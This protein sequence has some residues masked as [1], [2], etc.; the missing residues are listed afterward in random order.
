MEL[1]GNLQPMLFQKNSVSIPGP[2]QTPQSS[3]SPTQSSIS[4]QI[5]SCQHLHLHYISTII[6]FTNTIINI[7]AN[8][9]IVQSLFSSYG[10]SSTSPHVPS[11]ST[12]FSGSSK[13]ISEQSV[14]LIG[15]LDMYFFWQFKQ[16]KVLLPDYLIHHHQYLNNTLMVRIITI[17][18]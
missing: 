3:Y 8:T 2:L 13:H 18:T 15:K 17:A 10:H 14:P 7:I 4:S 12:S 11:W 1:F 5:P 9:I 6:I 16:Y